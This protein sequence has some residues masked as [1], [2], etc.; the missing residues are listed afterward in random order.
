M[1]G[2]ATHTAHVLLLLLLL[3]LLR[4]LLLLHTALPRHPPAEDDGREG[5]FFNVGTEEVLG[6]YSTK[7]FRGA[8]LGR[9]PLFPSVHP[10]FGQRDIG[11]YFK[12]EP[13]LFTRQTFTT[14][15]Q[16]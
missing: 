14:R 13:F 6:V 9:P 3:R 12:S 4:R 10:F 11:S 16:Y 15:T 8:T 2:S 5:Q 1:C 7:F